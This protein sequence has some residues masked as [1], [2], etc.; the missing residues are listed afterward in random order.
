MAITVVKNV[1]LFDGKDV[2]PDTYV[3]FDS[4]AG[5]IIEVSNNP[6]SVPA[7]ATVVDG[8][9]YTL[10]PGLIDA[11]AHSHLMH[12]SREAMSYP[13]LEVALQGGITTVCDLHCNKS[14]IDELWAEI[15]QDIHQAKQAGATG[16][17]TKA[18]LKT[19]LS[20]A[21]IK[22]GYPKQMVLANH[23]NAEVRVL[24]MTLVILQWELIFPFSTSRCIP[25]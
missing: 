6:V 13:L 4:D 23:P 17:V 10:I 22:G 16:R 9:G 25:S 24:W 21:T 3:V 15:D 18:D 2:R 7:D 19:A 20:A 14:R 5:V 1:K 12:G 11:H 8:S